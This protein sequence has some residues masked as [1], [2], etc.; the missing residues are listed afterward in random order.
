MRLGIVG[1]GTIAATYVQTLAHLGDTFSIT[2]LFD[3][4]PEKAEGL[5]IAGAVICPTLD[6]LLQR[7]DVD[8]V[9][10]STPLG[11]HV[12][13]AEACLQ[14]KKHVLLEKPAALSVP[15]IERLFDLAAEMDV[16]FYVGFH[17]SFGVDITWYLQTLGKTH[18]LL[19]LEEI[20]SVECNFF[21]PYVTDGEMIQDRKPLG[22]SYIDSGVNIFSVCSRLMPIEEMAVVSHSAK[23]TRDGVVYASETV[24]AGGKIRITARTGWDRGQNHKST[25][26]GFARTE[27]ALLLDHTAQAV[28]LLKKDGEKQLLYQENGLQR[29]VNQYIMVF[30]MFAQALEQ[31]KPIPHRNQ[32]AAIHK[33]LL[34]VGAEGIGTL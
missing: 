15:E 5:G 2:A 16:T 21:D 1:C 18:P 23:K 10:I 25:L 24:V 12:A 30:K 13:V 29:M 33:L 6:A 19:G 34:S 8:G 17:S 7:Q 27:D 3:V 9:V 4:Q 28:W 22:G 20:Q 14:K 31:K 11:T 26:L 32:V